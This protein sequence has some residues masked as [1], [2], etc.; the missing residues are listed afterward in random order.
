MNLYVRLAWAEFLLMHND[1][2]VNDAQFELGWVSAAPGQDLSE[3][4]K[5]LFPRGLPSP[6]SA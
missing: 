4:E 1:S 6:R 5:Y 3:A 2:R